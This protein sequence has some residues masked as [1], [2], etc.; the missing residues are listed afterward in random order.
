M[1]QNEELT[2]RQCEFRI[3]LSRIVGEFDLVRSIQYLY[4]SA[5]L[6]SHKTMV[7][8]VGKQCYDIKLTWLGVHTDLPYIT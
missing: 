3:C 7:R 5:H 4:H 6:T 8:Q 2:L 1:V